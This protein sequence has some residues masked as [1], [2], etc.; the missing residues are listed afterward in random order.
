MIPRR[1]G[2]RSRWARGRVGK[3]GRSPGGRAVIVHYGDW[4]PTARGDRARLSGRPP[5]FRITVVDNGGEDGTAGPGARGG[6]IRAGRNRG[7]RRRRAIS[8]RR[9][10]RAD[11]L[12]FLNNDVELAPGSDRHA[13]SGP[14]AGPRG[15]RPSRPGSSDA[16]RARRPS[17]DRPRPTPRRVLFEGLFLPRIFPGIPFFHGH[18]TRPLT[19]GRARDVETALRRRCSS[20]GGRPSSRSAASTRRSS[21]TPRRA[22][23]SRG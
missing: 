10:A 6:W 5:T 1:D 8:A 14:R 21:S 13:R 18:H 2:W 20:S 22:I 11:F 23:S 12:L 3:A 9:R 15:S 19:H 17:L 4:A 16:E 7:L